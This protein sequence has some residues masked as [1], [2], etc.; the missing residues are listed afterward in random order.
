LRDTP[1]TE[2]KKP[3]AEWHVETG[4]EA[5]VIANLGM[6]ADL[7]VAGRGGE[8]NMTDR[9]ILEAAL[10]DTGRALLIPG[11]AAASAIVGETIAIAWKPTPQA[12]RA[13]TAAMPF[14]ALGA[15]IIV[16][17][18]EEGEGHAGGEQLV[19]NLHWHGFRAR[20]ERIS[21]DGRDPVEALLEMVTDRAGLVVMGGYGHSR[22]REWVFGGFTQRLL[23]DAP[24]SVLMIH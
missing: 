23:A 13:V 7:I 14:L 21:A 24:L 8:D 4:E 22:F 12:A 5:R 16:V 15:E 1:T 11:K 2:A 20:A 6:M 10:L 17:T 19:R 3:T 18:V 9:S